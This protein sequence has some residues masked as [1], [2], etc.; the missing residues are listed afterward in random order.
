[1]NLLSVD[2][3]FE[4]ARI[5]TVDV[6]FSAARFPTIPKKA[7]LIKRSIERLQTLPGVASAGVTNKLP[8]P[9]EGSNNSMIAEG[10]ATTE[11]LVADIR[12]VNTDFLRTMG[13]PLYQSRTFDE[14]DRLIRE[15]LPS[16]SEPIWSLLLRLTTFAQ[17]FTTSIQSCRCPHS[18]RWTMCCR[19]PLP[20]GGS[21]CIWCCRSH[22]PLWFWR[23]SACTV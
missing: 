9:G 2:R 21:K 22:W 19:K 18:G 7:E 10:A 11:R 15:V 8:L 1:M 14:R 13:I 17:R 12:T 3:G 16:S 6:N 23:V 5:D 20:N 4:T